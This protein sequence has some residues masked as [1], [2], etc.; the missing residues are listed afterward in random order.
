M[1]DK[2]LEKRDKR[3]H[4]GIVKRIVNQLVVFL[5]Q[6]ISKLPFWVIYGISD[7]MYLLVRYVVKYRKKV[8]FE[9]LSHAFPD[10]NEHEIKEIANKFYRHFCD[11]SLETVKMHS[12]TEKQM[13]KRMKL[14]GVDPVNTYAERGQSVMI[15]GFHY[16][17]W[18][19]QSSIQSKSKHQL[20]IVYNPLRGNA[21]MERFISHS[22]EKWGGKS[23]PVHKSVR[24]ILEYVKKGEPAALWLAADQTPKASSPFWTVFLNREAPFFT[25]PEKIAIKTN[26]PIVFLYLKKTGRGK[27]E[28]VPSI[29]IKEP[30]TLEPKD[31]LLTYIRKME[32]IINE[33]PEYY[34]WSHRR[35]KHSRPEG[36]E[37]TL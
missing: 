18:E 26:Q 19:W 30:A 27:Y 8:I 1:A 9:N 21:A 31:I 16:N 29:L 33:T 15:L 17:N 10:K 34:L 3:F 6:I 22:R 13:D 11:F 25:G 36:I 23:V 2:E 28:A 20:L 37:L 32:E 7:F 24:A 14:T 5:L 12:M 35:W 4:E